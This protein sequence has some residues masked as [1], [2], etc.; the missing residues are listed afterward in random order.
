MSTLRPDRWTAHHPTKCG[1]DEMP[2][3]YPCRCPRF[4]PRRAAWWN[5]TLAIG[6]K[7]VDDLMN[8][9]AQEQERAV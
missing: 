8:E 2:E 7:A 9:W 3:G 4:W 1:A 5:G 6:Q